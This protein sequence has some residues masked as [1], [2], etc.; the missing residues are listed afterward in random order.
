MLGMRC[1]ECGEVRW[2]IFGIA[3][4]QEGECPACGATMVQERRHP[5]QRPAPGQPGERRVA[6]PIT[7]A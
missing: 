2:P 7:T 4:D 3:R 5:G 1:E 6:P